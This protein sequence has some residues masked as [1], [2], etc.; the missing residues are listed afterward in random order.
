L[1]LVYLPVCLAVFRLYYCNAEGYLDCDPE[2]SCSGV[3]YIGFTAVCTV[4]MA[5][6]LVGMPWLLYLLVQQSVVYS[7]SRDHEKRLQATELSYTLGIDSLWLSCQCWLCSSFHRKRIFFLVQMLAL[8]AAVLVLFVFL[9]SSFVAQSSL[10][11]LVLA[12]FFLH[13]TV[14]W[15]YRVRSSN[16]TLFTLMALIFIVNTYYAMDAFG[17]VNAFTVASSQFYGM[18]VFFSIAVVSLLAI[19]AHALINSHTQNWPSTL[20]LNA[21]LDSN[22]RDMALK[23]ITALRRARNV[24]LSSFLEPDQTVDINSIERSIRRL[25]RG[26]LAARSRGS[27]FEVLLSDAL[28][29]LL[30][31]HSER[32]PSAYRRDMAWEKDIA[33]KV[34]AVNKRAERT[35]LVSK[36]G[37]RL[38]LKVLAVR[39]FSQKLDVARVEETS[40]AA[41]AAAPE[42]PVPNSGF[43]DLLSYDPADGD[44]ME[45][46]EVPHLRMRRNS[47][48]VAEE[49]ADDADYGD[50][51][52]DDDDIEGGQ[53]YSEDE[54]DEVELEL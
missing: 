9:R 37:R 36:L 7:Q 49:A 22:G 42:S 24:R 47:Y 26:W 13:W 31:I 18:L 29:Q 41:A 8:K 1:Q 30:K 44:Q 17:V 53:G 54:E 46:F 6:Y 28:D 15:P 32:Y 20:T 21:I 38:L 16:L 40:A 19:T 33:A 35:A 11:W 14:K 34:A 51:D 27:I 45:E 25:R 43:Y 12:C 39:A 2:V 48:L 23:W 4:L 3:F 52:D 50:G 5:P 10:I